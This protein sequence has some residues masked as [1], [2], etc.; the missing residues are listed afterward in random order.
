MD[1]THTTTSATTHA[2]LVDAILEANP[3]ADRHWLLCFTVAE[4][5][6]YLERL[7]RTG[8]CEPDSL[9]WERVADTPAVVHRTA[10]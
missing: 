10:A 3:G 4:L 2:S 9:C 7:R 1:A 8:D 5:E 6:G